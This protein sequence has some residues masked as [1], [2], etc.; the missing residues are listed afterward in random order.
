MTAL[1]MQQGVR[2]G[3]A[4]Y[5]QMPTPPNAPSV[6]A[7]PASQGSNAAADFAALQASSG[8]ERFATLWEQMM[9]KY[10]SAD[11][12]N[13]MLIGQ[14]RGGQSGQLPPG[15][16]P[17]GMPQQPGQVAPPQPP[18]SIPQQMM[19]NMQQGFQLGGLLNDA[20]NGPQTPASGAPSGQPPLNPLAGLQPSA[21]PQ[22][23]GL[24]SQPNPGMPR[25]RPPQG[26][27]GMNMPQMGAMNRQQM[28][29]QQ[30]PPRPVNTAG[31]AAMAQGQ[32]VPGGGP[33]GGY[34]PQHINRFL[35]KQEPHSGAR[36]PYPV[37]LPSWEQAMFETQDAW[38]NRG[39][40]SGLFGIS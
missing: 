31:M 15:N 13:Q 10:G 1:P 26:P 14:A 4:G 23:Q 17:P 39:G 34:A 25:Q 16:Q 7:Q 24:P 28:G 2:G 36:D 40:L 11:N 37:P 3:L 5:P 18:T 9:E 8:S 21:S 38:Q 19:Q 30:G 32:Q 12:L 6:F 29:P 27:P 22:G 33:Q 20:W 35:N